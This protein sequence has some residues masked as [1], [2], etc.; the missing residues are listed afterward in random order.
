M[1]LFVACALLCS[2]SAFGAL[3]PYNQTSKEIRDVLSHP[4]VMEAFAP[5]SISSIDKKDYGY[6]ITGQGCYLKV[7]IHYKNTGLIGPA[8]YDIEIPQPLL[9]E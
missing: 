2:S 1:K 5:Q 6:W 9:C 4:E 8:Q 7:E 3:S